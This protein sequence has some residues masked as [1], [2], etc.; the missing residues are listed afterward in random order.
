[1]T[2]R[3]VLLCVA[4]IALALLLGCATYAALTSIQ[5]SPGAATV[6]AGN[7]AQLTASGTS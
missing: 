5:V 2:G 6:G 4:F 7:T 3:L 1:M